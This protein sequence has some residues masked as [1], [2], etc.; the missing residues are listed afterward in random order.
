M[1]IKITLAQLNVVYGDFSANREKAF[2][3]IQAA[4]ASGSDLILFPELWSSGYD[5][6]NS[7]K[8]AE[9]NETL[10]PQLQ[11]ISD[12]NQISITGSLI[13]SRDN[14]LFNTFAW[15]RPGAALL[16]YNK[17]HLFQLLGEKDH[18]SPGNR[19]VMGSF[20][21]FTVGLS[22]CYDLRFPDLFRI[23]AG[24]GAS[25]LLLCAEWPAIRIDHWNLL[26]Q[27]RAV[28]NQTFLAAVNA[29]GPSGNEVF[30]GCSRVVDPSGKILAECPSDGESLLQVE[31]DDLEIVRSRE[32]M[33]SFSDRQEDA[34]RNPL[35]YGD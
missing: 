34:Y 23:Y 21:G 2:S 25:L 16:R 18:L 8:Y 6:S 11:T 27:A 24:N 12:E 9:L 17:I 4:A 31:L 30:G 22:I 7:R 28:E 32:R 35:I 3:A 15:V 13:E 29:V 1:K 10:L 33:Y 14:S 26:T 20:K 5:L 19:P